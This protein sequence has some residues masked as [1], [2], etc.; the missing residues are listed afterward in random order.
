MKQIGLLGRIWSPVWPWSALH[1]PMLPYLG[2]D[3]GGFALASF[4]GLFISDPLKGILHDNCTHPNV[5]R[6]QLQS[7]LLQQPRD[8]RKTWTVGHVENKIPGKSPLRHLMD[9]A[10][11][12]FG[13]FAEFD[14]AVPDDGTSALAALIHSANP[15]CR[16]NLWKKA[17]VSI[18]YQSRYAESHKRDKSEPPNRHAAFSL[19]KIKQELP[20][21]GQSKP[22]SERR[23]R[24]PGEQYWDWMEFVEHVEAT[25]LEWELA[26]EDL[27][28]VR[29]CRQSMTEYD[30]RKYLNKLEKLDDF[31]LRIG[32][33]LL[34]PEFRVFHI[35]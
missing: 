16:D 3:F 4:V 13:L 15:S 27:E 2:D 22:C 30:W 20:H 14:Q 18:D 32:V 23:V 34:E 12:T 11:T 26:K 19:N 35:L 24:F 33:N 10:D 28:E 31:G 17:S 7:T 29:M 5:C 6:E 25:I 21:A 8:S 9:W 1:V